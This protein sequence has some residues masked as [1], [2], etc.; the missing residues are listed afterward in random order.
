[1]G[2]REAPA[3]C[4]SSG[5]IR[6][7]PH[8][9]SPAWRRS[10][11]SRCPASGGDCR[12]EERFD[13]VVKGIWAATV[14]TIGSGTYL[15]LKQTAYKTPFSTSALTGVFALPYGRPYFLSLGAK[16]GLYALMVLASIPLIREA[17]RHLRSGSEADISEP[18]Q[19]RAARGSGSDPWGPTTERATGARTLVVDAPAEAPA[20]RPADP[21]LG[22]TV[23]RSESFQ[24][25]LAAAIVAAGGIGIWMCVTLLKYFH[26]L[27]EASRLR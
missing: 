27:V 4:S 11:P 13:L 25:R 23:D 19:M 17:G 2:S 22:A 15:L 12:H 8:F 18:S 16:L 5:P 3:R 9:G 7:P 26:E 24:V 21:P 20:A 1:V 10:S 6:W 14:L